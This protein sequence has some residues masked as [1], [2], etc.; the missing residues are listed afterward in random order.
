MAV[1]L[2]QDV[3]R[4]GDALVAL[5]ETARERKADL[6]LV[7]EPPEFVGHRHPA[8]E[9]LQAG[10]VMMAR[11]ID[12]D[13]TISAEEGL[14]RDAEG[15]VQVLVLGRRGHKGR[16]LRVV[17]SYHQGTGRRRRDRGA[18]RAKWDE[19]LLE[20]CILAGDFNAHSPVWNPQCTRNQCRDALFLEELIEVHELVV[21]NNV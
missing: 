15:D 6:V 20:D 10:R 18:T 19:I 11:R 2:Q 14:T 13:W 8:F 12:S 5:M 3:A 4:Q 21:K 1:I 9:F 17:N 7:Q 16:E